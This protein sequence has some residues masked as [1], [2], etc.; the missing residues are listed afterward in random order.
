MYDERTCKST[1]SAWSV[2]GKGEY[3]PELWFYEA[4]LAEDES[5][6]TLT[7]WT[8]ASFTK[9]A[10]GK[11]SDF[12]GGQYWAYDNATELDE[13]IGE[14]LPFREFAYGPIPHDD[15]DAVCFG[16]DTA[17]ER[18]YA[19]AYGIKLPEHERKVKSYNATITETLSRTVT[20]KANSEDEAHARIE[21]E[22]RNEV[23][24][25]GAEDFKDVHFTV[26][27]RPHD[28]GLTR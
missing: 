4:H 14:T 15:F 21:K 2:C 7:S 5:S 12:N 27:E 26:A 23:H 24:V 11:W 16:G 1:E 3:G 6:P 8:F 25:L 13:V 19:A 9:D 17:K 10:D 18:E 28:K 22:W 20:V